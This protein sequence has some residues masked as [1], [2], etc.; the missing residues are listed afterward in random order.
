[1]LKHA[2]DLS[3]SHEYFIVWVGETNAR[4]WGTKAEGYSLFPEFE[5]AA[6]GVDLTVVAV[7]GSST[8]GSTGTFNVT[9]AT[10]LKANEFANA[11]LRLGTKTVPITGHGV[12]QSHVA[13]P[14]GTPAALTVVW[15]VGAAEAT[16]AGYIV[17]ENAK[18]RSHPQV[19]VLT[20]YQPVSTP[21]SA[22]GVDSA[23]GTDISYP[24]PSSTTTTRS[25]TLPA[26]YNGTSGATSHEDIGV[27]LPFSFHEGIDGY[28]FSEGN[29]S[30]GATDHAFNSIASDGS[31]LT[32]DNALP[33]GLDIMNGGYLIID[34]LED[35]GSM[36]RSWAQISD[37]TATVLVVTDWLGDSIGDASTGLLKGGVAATRAGR[38]KRFTA[39]IPHYNDSPYAFLPG[40]GYTYPNNDMM[41]YAATAIGANVHNRPRGITGNA[42]GDKFGEMLVAASR[43]SAAIG[44][45]VNV[46]HLGINESSL[47]PSNASNL[48]G[49]DGKVG[50]WDAENHGTW[51]TNVTT[52]LYQR[53]DK[54]LRTVLPNALKAESSAKTL[55][56]L[57]LV[58]SQGQADALNTSARQ[59][60][61][62]TLK[63]FVSSLRSLINTL[64]FNPYAN[65]A[66]IPYVQPRIAYLPYSVDDA[67]MKHTELGGGADPVDYNADIDGLTNSA[68][69]ENSISD[70]FAASVKVDDLPRLAADMSLFNGVGEAELGSRISD[71]L[72]IL[73]DYGLAHGSTALATAQTRAIDIC[74]MALSGIGDSGQIVSLDDGSEQAAL[75]KRFL[76]EARDSLL[77]MRQWGF[78]LRRRQLVSIQ[79]PEPAV[80]QHFNSCYVMPADALNAFTVLPPVTSPST[81]DHT[82]VATSSYSTTFV[83]NDGSGTAGDDSTE[84]SKV[85]VPSGPSGDSG[86]VVEPETILPI[87][88][89]IEL[90]PEPYTVEQSPFGHRYIFTN[91][92]FATLQYVARVVDADQY[93]PHFAT[94]LASYLGSMLA[95]VLIKGDEGEKVSARL[96]QKTAGAVRQ[97]STS[98]A[99]QQR[100]ID[101][102]RPFGFMPDHIANR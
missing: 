13:I 69:E 95:G 101:S 96:L 34:W 38:I 22:G 7:P 5:N 86:V 17:R 85:I 30:A 6:D 62:R 67:Y 75:C 29:D 47:A 91:Q 97:A 44:K 83:T 89:H 40:E 12:I 68:I 24:T 70:G 81:F 61:G 50:W 28:G 41:P 98:D 65:G 76:P 23:T 64:G 43:L 63:G 14:A 72:G 54:L 90:N 20:P 99:N 78:A 26:P 88:A 37:S 87:Q 31:S 18:W 36:K 49:F 3:D 73:I 33:G 74:N 11:T 59:H 15:T 35:S 56:C 25:L 9:C 16:P 45:R 82:A 32:F 2:A 84:D 79:R 42:Y 102:H 51:A 21:A 10:A 39:W 52:S 27:L 60:Y 93:S 58:V 94:A 80:Y 19:R 4:P 71:K 46:V 53:L 55:R 48:T 92:T 1:M 100:P 66:E 8:A 77:Q 57:G